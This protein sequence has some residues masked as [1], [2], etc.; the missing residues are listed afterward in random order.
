MGFDQKRMVGSRKSGKC[1]P[2]SPRSLDKSSGFYRRLQD[3][4]DMDDRSSLNEELSCSELEVNLLCE[5]KLESADTQGKSPLIPRSSK[6][7]SKRKSR[8]RASD[9]LPAAD[10]SQTP[11]LGISELVHEVQELP[12]EQ[13]NQAVHFTVLR[14][15]TRL[16]VEGLEGK[17]MEDGQKRKKQH[18]AKKY[19]KSI[20]KA[21]RRRWEFFVSSIQRRPLLN[22]SQST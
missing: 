14:E 10:G 22:G 8:Q 17:K 1:S 3:T 13:P 2:K 21:F 4:E 11:I 19:R 9:H 7:S 16:L 20:N 12:T 15:E 5:S 6:Q 18:K